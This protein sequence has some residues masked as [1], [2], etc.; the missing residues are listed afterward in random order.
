MAKH[1]LISI[2]IPVKNGDAWLED[3][4][5]SIYQQTLASNIEVIIIDS[6]S[7]DATFDILSNYPV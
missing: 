4:L 3:T 2:V 1:P 5:K 6:G 7:T